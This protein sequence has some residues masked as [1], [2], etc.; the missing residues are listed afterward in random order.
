MKACFQRFIAVVVVEISVAAPVQLRVFHFDFDVRVRGDWTPAVAALAVKMEA[1]V[2]QTAGRY[3][4]AATQAPWQWR[5][6]FLDIN[7]EFI[8]A[9]LQGAWA[10]CECI[11]RAVYLR[12]VTLRHGPAARRAI[13]RHIDRT[14]LLGVGVAFASR[15]FV[16]G[17]ENA[18]DEGDNCQPVGAVIAERVD[19]PPCVA[20][21]YD[22]YREVR[23]CR[24][25][26]AAAHPE[27][28]AIGTPGPG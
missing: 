7:Y 28:A 19:V 8:V 12:R 27:S 13:E 5:C 25:H 3:S 14:V 24:T 22:G 2:E 17:R 4:Y 18:A 11:M 10:Y 20:I 16:V 6:N 26:V 1:L 23:S 15:P 21:A 9:P